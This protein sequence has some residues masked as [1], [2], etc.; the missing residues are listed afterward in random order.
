MHT[1]RSNGQRATRWRPGV[2][3]AAA[4]AC[5]TLVLANAGPLQ[6]QAR[7]QATAPQGV[8]TGRV[9]DAQTSGPVQGVVVRLVELERLAETD[10]NGIFM[11][12]GVPAGFYAVQ[13]ERIGYNPHR[14]VW[15][16]GSDS[17]TARIS[18]QVRLE[19]KPL[20]L[21]G[22]EVVVER[23]E[24][25]MRSM[26]APVRVFQGLRMPPRDGGSGLSLVMRAGGLAIVECGILQR[27]GGLCV[28]VRGVPQTPVVFID[29]RL[30]PGGMEDLDLLRPDQIERIEL[31]HGGSHIRVYTTWF[32]EWVALRPGFRPFPIPPSGLRM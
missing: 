15:A 19:P 10:A 1:P 20:T 22:L 24:T 2:V 23:L 25:R 8:I 32:M 3:V 26:G 13:V 6:A 31:L 4:V 14:D 18:M 21:Q 5:C 9:V 29:E 11:L 27:S 7:D 12:S 30:S 28:S 17:A 16:L